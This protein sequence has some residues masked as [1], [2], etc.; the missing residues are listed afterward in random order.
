MQQHTDFGPMKNAPVINALKNLQSILLLQNELTDNLG[1]AQ[2]RI[3]DL[4]SKLATSESEKETILAA[5]LE[6]IDGTITAQLECN[7]ECLP[8][9]N[10]T[11]KPIIDSKDLSA[12]LLRDLF[13]GGARTK[14]V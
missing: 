7:A 2:D 6:T 11:I 10:I 13:I 1:S 3:K 5:L 8:Q 4:E 14:T 9:I 12:I